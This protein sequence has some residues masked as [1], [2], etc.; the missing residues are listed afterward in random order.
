MYMHRNM[1]DK[2]IGT[3]A[4]CDIISTGIWYGDLPDGVPKEVK[5]NRKDYYNSRSCLLSP[6][7]R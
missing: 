4:S 7:T 1:T 5:F 3:V 6:T 2:F